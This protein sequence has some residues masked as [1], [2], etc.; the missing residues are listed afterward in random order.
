MF[1]LGDDYF[2]PTKILLPPGD[3]G[4]RLLAEVTITVVEDIEKA[5]GERFKNLSYNLGTGNGKEE[6]IISYSELVDH[7][8]DTANEESRINDDLYKFKALNGHQGHLK[9]P[10]PNLKGCRYI[11]LVEWETGEKTYEPLSVL[12][13]DDPVTCASYTKEMVFHIL[14]V[15]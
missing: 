15:G 4:E 9:T 5:D 11:I 14:M 1:H 6:E 2:C 10:N 3:N 13:E 7:L 8:E 12:A